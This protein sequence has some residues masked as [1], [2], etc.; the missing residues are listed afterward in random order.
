[1]KLLGKILLICALLMGAYG[2]EKTQKSSEEIYLDYTSWNSDERSFL[3]CSDGTCLVDYKYDDDGWWNYSGLRKQYTYILEY[4]DVYLELSDGESQHIYDGNGK[5]IYMVPSKYQGSIFKSSSGNWM[6]NLKNLNNGYTLLPMQLSPSCPNI[7]ICPFFEEEIPDKYLY[8]CG[9]DWHS[10]DI[11]LSFSVKDCWVEY[12]NYS[13]LADRKKQFKFTLEYP[14]VY[15]E[16]KEDESQHILGQDG[17]PVYTVPSKY[18][19]TIFKSSS[20]EWEMNLTDLNTGN[21]TSAPLTL[22]KYPDIPLP[23]FFSK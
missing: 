23:P 6:M 16:L 14:Y 10:N 19:G 9:T 21:T 11:H 2:C 20:G 8:L 7:P 3:F 12:E 1:M 4:P 5:P 18:Q 15:M 13:P 22:V 17:F